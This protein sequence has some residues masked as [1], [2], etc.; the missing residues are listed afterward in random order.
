MPA[1]PFNPNQGCRHHIPRHQHKVTNRPAYETGLR[2]LAQIA[3][4]QRLSR[5]WKPK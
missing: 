4:A 5:E 2:Q 3:E 1:L